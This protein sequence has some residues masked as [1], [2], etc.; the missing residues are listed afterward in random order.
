MK[1]AAGWNNQYKHISEFAFD[2]KRPL[3]N[4]EES[5]HIHINLN[6]KRHEEFRSS[7]SISENKTYPSWFGIEKKMCI[8]LFFKSIMLYFPITITSAK[9][10]H[11]KRHQ[12]NSNPGFL[13]NC[14]ELLYCLDLVTLATTII[15][16]ILK[17]WFASTWIAAFS[18]RPTLTTT[19]PIILKTWF[20]RAQIAALC[21]VTVGW[22]STWRWADPGT[23][24]ID[25]WKQ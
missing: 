19:V 6:V 12:R 10:T 5:W 16:F 7:K 1:E 15:F 9:Q 18:Y 17:T 25:I 11:Y 14:Q 22:G 13:I 4:L 8:S 23:A 24:F 21:V 3:L 2:F 20:A